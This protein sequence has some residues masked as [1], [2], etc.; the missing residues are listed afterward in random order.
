MGM[1]VNFMWQLNWATVLRHLIKDYS[2]C[3]CE[4]GFSDEINI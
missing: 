1:T 3:F 2:G 4:G